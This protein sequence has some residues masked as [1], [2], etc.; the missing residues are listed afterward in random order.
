MYKVETILETKTIFR[1]Y[2]LSED[3]VPRQNRTGSG[4]GVCSI[5]VRIYFSFRVRAF[6]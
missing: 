6:G 4:C 1:K 2:N 5:I 3:G